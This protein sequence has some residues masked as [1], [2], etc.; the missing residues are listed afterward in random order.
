MH[1]GCHNSFAEEVDSRTAGEIEGYATQVVGSRID[2][3]VE[4]KASG[5]YNDL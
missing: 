5:D 2:Q 1:I 3:A 4:G